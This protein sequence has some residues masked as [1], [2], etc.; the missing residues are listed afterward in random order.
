MSKSAAVS[1][2]MPELSIVIPVYGDIENL[3]RCYA[4]IR[5]NTKLRYEIIFVDDESPDQEMLRTFFDGI[6]N[7]SGVTI[8]HNPKNMG[9]GQTANKG[10]SRVRAPI[11]VFVSSDVFVKEE[12]LDR[13]HAEF[14]NDPLLG[15]VGPKLLFP[16]D[17]KDPSTRPPGKIQHAGLAFNVAGSPYHMFMGWSEDNPRVNIKKQVQAVTGACFMTRTEVF[18]TQG[19][20]ADVYGKGTYEDMEFCIVTRVG[21]RKVLY[22]PTAVAYHHV[23]SSIGK[24][25]ERGEGG[26]DLE[27]NASIFRIRVGQAIHW[28]EWYHL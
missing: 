9:F 10:V 6:K 26:F 13:M 22:L 3:Q 25:V 7:D 16:L 18:K 5:K 11:V 23:G 12:C 27:R 4:E 14:V 2:F 20:F 1:S 21:G 8:L 24:A 15:V 17:S 19:G 28:D